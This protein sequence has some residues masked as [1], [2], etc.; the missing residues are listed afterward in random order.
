[1]VNLVEFRHALDL[2]DRL[3]SKATVDRALQSAGLSR[4][5]VDRGNGFIPYRFEAQVLEYVARAIGDADLGAHLAQ[6]FDYSIYDA[7][8]RY[9]LGASNLGAALE[10]GR[11]AFALL[12]PGSEIVLRETDTHLLVGRRSGLVTVIG[13]R[14]LDDAAIIIIGQVARHFLGPDWRPSWIEATG[15][16]ASRTAFLEKATGA[17]VRTGA[18]MPAIAIERPALSA[19]NPSPPSAHLTIGFAELPALMKI[20]PPRTMADAVMQVLSTQLVVGDLSEESV[21]SR[22]SVGRRTLQRAL[23]A[24][25]T[26]F[27]ELRARFIAARA[28]SLLSESELDVPSIARALGYGEPNSFRRAFSGWT[29]QT[30]DAYRAATRR[31]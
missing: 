2:L 16:G 10:R 6:H 14:H 4:K 31:P 12:H 25:A 20:E 27:R 13:H 21:A 9:V 30:P 11:R 26:S 19:L 22:L 28:R 5:L 23:K 18:E 8:A 15:D 17:P 1:M 29:G 7:Y 3:A 24:E